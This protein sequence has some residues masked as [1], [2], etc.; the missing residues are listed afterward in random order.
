MNYTSDSIISLPERHIFV[1]GSN[2]GGRHG[3]GA[4]KVAMQ[5]FGAKYGK[6]SGLQG[7]SYG[8]PTKDRS[9]KVL[10]IE[11]IRIGVDKFLRFADNNKELTFVVT[12]IGCGLAGLREKD[13]A[14]MFTGAPSNVVLPEGWGNE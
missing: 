3:R 14:P 11:K 4:A 6:G 2:Y 13:I 7:R 5:K 12:K 10:S 1:F 9:L 8:I